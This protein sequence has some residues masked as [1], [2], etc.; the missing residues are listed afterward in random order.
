M[1]DLLT[2]LP[3]FSQFRAIEEYSGLPPPAEKTTSLTQLAHW[4]DWPRRKYLPFHNFAV[5]TIRAGNTPDCK[6]GRNALFSWLLPVAKTS[7]L[8]AMIFFIVSV[9]RF[10]WL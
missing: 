1:A 4:Q 5:L 8:N 3:H 2:G 7:K 6:I 10:Q 9:F